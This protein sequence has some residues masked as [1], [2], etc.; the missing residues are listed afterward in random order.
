M[1][2]LGGRARACQIYPNKLCRAMLTGIKQ[3]LAHSGII[4]GKDEDMLMVNAD[5]RNCEDYLDQYVDDISGQPLQR[6]FVQEASTAEMS[7]FSAH[8]V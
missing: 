8:D 7:T 6:Q 1:P 2:L 3:E 4:Q 5:D